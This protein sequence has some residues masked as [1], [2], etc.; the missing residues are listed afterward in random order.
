M[1]FVNGA[2][3][4]AGLGAIALATLAYSSQIDPN[5]GT[6]QAEPRVEFEAASATHASCES[7]VWPYIPQE[8]LTDE[9][10]LSM[11]SVNTAGL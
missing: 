4:A 7:A 3:I 1:Y 11:K 6:A 8:C 10:D 2:A 5:A 9:R